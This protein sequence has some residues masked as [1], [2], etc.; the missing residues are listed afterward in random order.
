MPRRM[1]LVDKGTQAGTCSSL[2]L[3]TGPATYLCFRNLDRMAF[4]IKTTFY[5]MKIRH[6]KLSSSLVLNEQNLKKATF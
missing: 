1:H 5:G 4:N 3:A 6:K 2:A